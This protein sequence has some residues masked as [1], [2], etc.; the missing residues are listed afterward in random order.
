MV[1]FNAFNVAQVIDRTETALVVAGGDD[2]FRK[3]SRDTGYFLEVGRTRP[4][5][6]QF[7]HDDTPVMSPSEQSIVS[8]DSLHRL[9][10]SLAF[11]ERRE[12]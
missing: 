3:V 8:I 5:E 9:Q 1:V 7:L 11:R 2:A 10:V 6:V 12:S 4:V